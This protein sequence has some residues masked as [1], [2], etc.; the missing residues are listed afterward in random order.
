M[1]S[2][3]EKLIYICNFIKKIKFGTTNFQYKPFER[4]EYYVLHKLQ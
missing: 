3:N 2:V 4:L 1:K